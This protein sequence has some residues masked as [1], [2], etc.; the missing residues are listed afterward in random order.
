MAKNYVSRAIT[1]RRE[2]LG[3]SKADLARL[4]GVSRTAITNWEAGHF[5]PRGKHV[6]E[7]AAALRVSRHDLLAPPRIQEPELLT[8]RGIVG[9]DVW[10]GKAADG[11]VETVPLLPDPR[12]PA[13]AQY[14][15]ELSDWHADQ[16]APKGSLLHC[17]DLSGGAGSPKP[18]DLVVIGCERGGLTEKTVRRIV[19]QDGETEWQWLC[20]APHESD[21]GKCMPVAAVLQ[22]LIRY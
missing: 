13:T 7:L 10:Q 12:F 16:I 18:G 21:R 4:L 17:L 15:L 6:D 3:L 11:R 14:A 20:D 9:I 8:L 22:I 5:D 19:Q 1:K 2:E